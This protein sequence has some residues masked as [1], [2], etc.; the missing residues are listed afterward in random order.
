[1]SSRVFPAAALAAGAILVACSGSSPTCTPGDAD[2][3]IGGA[4]TVLLNV[5]DTA[6]TVGGVDSGS[7]S[8]IISV[9]NEGNVSLKVT[10]VGTKP[11]DVDVLCIPSGLPAQCMQ[12]TSC[13]PGSAGSDPS[14][15]A[16]VPVLQ[17]GASTTVNFTAPVIEGVYPFVSDQPGD[18][19][20]ESDGGVE[21]LTGAFV[22]M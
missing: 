4:Y 17:P 19:E 22:L 10:N 16:L 8:N 21:G 7:T 13:F 12:Q 3:V 1:M 5:S 14:S 18:S 6:F 2:G 11:H 15:I 9:Q 20:V